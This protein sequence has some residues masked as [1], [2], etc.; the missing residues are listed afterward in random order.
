MFLTQHPNDV[1]LG[2][3][4]TAAAAAG[5]PPS[6]LV[7]F[8]QIFGY[9]GFS[10]FQELFKA[11]LKSGLAGAAS[12]R[13]ALAEPVAG[14]AAAPDNLLAMTAAA[15]ASL[16][17]L[18]EDFDAVAFAAVARTLAAS[19][20]IYLVGSK[21]AFPVTNYMALTFAQAGIKSVLVDNVGS[22][23]FDQ[24]GCLGPGDAVLAV[25][26]SPY[27]SITPELARLAGEKGAEVVSITDSLLS[28]LVGLSKA[29]LIVVEQSAAGYRSIAAT[30]VQGLHLVLA[31][32]ELRSE[33][34]GAAQAGGAGARTR[35]GA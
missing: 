18:E 19:G 15:K 16:A 6:T 33:V 23:A 34:R 29:S 13:A 30:M 4:S 35:R 31:V 27:N 25:S 11:H 3:I 21:R 2:T 14:T 20:L 10:E 32:A 8:A 1:A 24:I 28:P 5:V 7:R 9:S 17:R 12:L 22:T 26:F